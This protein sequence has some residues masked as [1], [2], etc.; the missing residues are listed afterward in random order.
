M[1]DGSVQCKVSEISRNSNCF[2]FDELKLQTFQYLDDKNFLPLLRFTEERIGYYYTCEQNK[3][4]IEP[5]LLSRIIGHFRAIKKVYKKN[6][7]LEN[8]ET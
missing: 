2:V 3:T 1:F 8:V 6:L 7:L 5:S 4:T